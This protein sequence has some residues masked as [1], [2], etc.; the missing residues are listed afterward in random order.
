MT[1][2]KYADS[3]CFIF[4]AGGY[5]EI[6]YS[7]LL[8]RQKTDKSYETK[9]FIPL[10]GMLMEVTQEQYISFYKDRRR[11]KY[12]RE[13]SAYNGDFSVDMLTTPEFDGEDILVSGDDVVEHIIN[14][15]MV[16]KLRD[17]LRLLTT[18]E[19][20]LI[21]DIFYNEITE[22]E[23]AVKHGVSQVTIHKRKK[24]ILEKLKKLLEN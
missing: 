10:H 2:E 18:E 16:D 7:E 15:I 5:E 24:R 22:R 17:T 12:L 9:K 11:Q 19:I 14:K 3:K 20:E 21:Q 8:R 13:R 6:T 23:L 1:E 4:S